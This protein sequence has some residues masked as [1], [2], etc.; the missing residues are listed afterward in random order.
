MVYAGESI[1][2]AFSRPRVSNTVEATL[3]TRIET[4]IS[5]AGVVVLNYYASLDSSC[6]A[7]VDTITIAAGSDGDLYAIAVSDDVLIQPQYAVHKMSA[8]QT[9]A[10]IATALAAQLNGFQTIKALAAADVIT[11][12]SEIP[13]RTLTISVADSTTPGNLTVAQTVAPSGTSI[14]RKVAVA[15]VKPSVKDVAGNP[16]KNGTVS[17]LGRVF[18]MDTDGMTVL[19]PS[20]GFGLLG[21]DSLRTLDAFQT[22]AGIAR[23]T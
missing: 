22:A 3:A 15:E 18:H 11:V 13:G 6:V 20:A 1:P 5:A 16:E 23:S 21:T 8:G 14:E 2:A 7:E 17:F 4:T 12:T 9:A 10:Q 19:N